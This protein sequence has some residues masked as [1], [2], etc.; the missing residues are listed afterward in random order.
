MKLFTYFR[1]SSSYRVRIALNLKGV[2]WRSEHVHLVRG[3]QHNHSY[4]ARNP[5]GRVPALEAAGKTMT[6]STAII[7][8]LEETVPEP[9]LLPTDP[10]ER[11][12]VR[13]MV[14]LVA[15]DIQPLNNLQVLK[16]LKDP[17]GHDQETVNTWYRHWIERGFAA[18]EKMVADSRGRFCHGDTPGMADVFLVPQVWN[19]R[20]FEVDMSAFPH[21]AAIDAACAELPAFRD[22]APE[23]QPDAE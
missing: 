1:S 6:Q 20:R 16:Y 3:E 11:A 5:Q 18:M 4:L 8:Y 2:R 15:C 21:L 7:E 23:N 22:A 17:L 19:A 13:S 12:H 14:G 9:P 10:G